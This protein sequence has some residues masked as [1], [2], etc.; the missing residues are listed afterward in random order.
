LKIGQIP[1]KIPG[2]FIQRETKGEKIMIKKDDNV[3]KTL[4]DRVPPH[5]F[6]AEESV[7]NAVLTIKDSLDKVREILKPEYFYKGAHK[8]IFAV[9]LECPAENGMVDVGILADELK[10]RD[11]FE[12]IGGATYLYY[13]MEESPIS[14]NLKQQAKI[15]HRCAVLRLAIDKSSETI[16]M[17]LRNDVE[18]LDIFLVKMEENLDEVKNTAFERAEA[19]KFDVSY[20]KFFGSD[21]GAV[22]TPF[23]SLNDLITGYGRKELVIVGGRWG[24]GKTAFCLRQARHTLIECQE[25]VIYCGAHMDADRIFLRLMAQISGVDFRKLVSG[26]P[27]RDKIK[28]VKEAYEMVYEA[29]K[30]MRFFFD[31]KELNLLSLQSRVETAIEE[32]KGNASLLIIE[33]LQ[34]LYWP[35]KDFGTNTFGKANFMIEKIKGW[36]QNI[37]P[38][39]MVSSQITRKATSRE[40]KRPELG[41]LFSD[42][43]ESLAEIVL[44]PYRPY[45]TNKK[46]ISKKSGAAFPEKDAEVIIAKGG[47]IGSIPMTFYGPSMN[48]EE[49]T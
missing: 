42:E 41:D 22:K 21:V 1:S 26:R 29:R 12:S 13:L 48:W 47:P 36:A 17:A 8:K 15:I 11:E 27:P 37:E 30:L 33:N 3:R 46:N 9:M 39:T 5:D 32:L 14:L 18:E 16:E 6:D 25:G 23:E 7:L 20:E 28:E 31:D 19:E 35:G 43:A 40:D 45:A 34:Q 4:L 24:M 49:R 10:R 2:Y 38:A 44:F